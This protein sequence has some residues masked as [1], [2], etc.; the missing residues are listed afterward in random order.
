M[1]NFQEIDKQNREKVLE[2]VQNRWGSDFIVSK[3]KKHFISDLDG[4]IV[5]ENEEIKGLIT[6]S[7][8]GTE[9]EI[10]SLDSFKENLGIGEELIKLVETEAGK[11]GC[12]RIWLITT[13]DNTRAL[14]FY[15][16]RG[17]VIENI[18]LNAIKE[19]RK[20]KPQI[21]ERGFGG[22]PILHEIEL[23]KEL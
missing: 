22:I 8:E 10:V 18:H 13:N 9:C 23:E 15:Q 21:P 16:K 2:L 1:F 19:S 14:R 20:L 4:F 3:G 12:K 7:I 17:F 6:Y 5:L 11:A